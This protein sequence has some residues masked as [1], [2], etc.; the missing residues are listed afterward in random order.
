MTVL[1]QKFRNVS[2]VLGNKLKAGSVVGKKLLSDVASQAIIGANRA[3]KL[4]GEI[5]RGIDVG[6]RQV[7]NVAGVVDR[8]LGRVNPYLSGTVVE[9]LAVGIRDASK[10]TRLLAPVAREK[11]QELVKLSERGYAKKVEDELKKFV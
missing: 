2:S 8:T 11:G 3:E 5:G 10:I 1:G 4:A 7:G 9:P 6:A